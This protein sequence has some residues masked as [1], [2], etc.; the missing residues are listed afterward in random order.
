MSKLF[1]FGVYEHSEKTAFHYFTN[2]FYD[3]Q[4]YWEYNYTAKFTCENKS[5]TGWDPILTL[6]EQ[7]ITSNT[8]IR[9]DISLSYVYKCIKR[10][11]IQGVKENCALITNPKLE[12][13]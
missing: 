12:T 5:S 3:M 1:F 2:S 13:I 6:P 11:E 10:I 4:F 9:G 7:E 8:I